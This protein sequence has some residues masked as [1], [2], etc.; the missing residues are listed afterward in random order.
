MTATIHFQIIDNPRWC[1]FIS[2]SWRSF[3][4]VSGRSDFTDVLYETTTT[5]GD[6]ARQ[7]WWEWV[8]QPNSKMMMTTVDWWMSQHTVVNS[9][10]STFGWLHRESNE[11]TLGVDVGKKRTSARNA[12]DAGRPFSELLLTTRKNESLKILLT[13]SHLLPPFYPWKILSTPWCT[14]TYIPSACYACL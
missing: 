8:T 1:A 7:I 4:V 12:N 6:R 5:I 3:L 13:S 11:S 2:A 14:T 9:W 10:S